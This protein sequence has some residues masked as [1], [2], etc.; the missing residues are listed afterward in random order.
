LQLIALATAN[1]PFF[2]ERPTGISIGKRTVSYLSGDFCPS[3][4]GTRRT[5][6]RYRPVSQFQIWIA[7]DELRNCLGAVQVLQ[8]QSDNRLRQAL[9]NRP[10]Q[11]TGT[12]RV[13]GP[14]PSWLEFQR[15]QLHKNSE[16]PVSPAPE[17]SM[18]ESSRG[19]I[20]FSLP[21][22][23][24]AACRHRKG[25]G[26]FRRNRHALLEAD[27]AVVSRFTRCAL[28]GFFVHRRSFALGRFGRFVPKGVTSYGRR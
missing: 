3:S 5:V 20:N 14:R 21:S 4:I 7:D 18:K 28:Y 17:C 13:I 9:G 16:I 24:W 15:N 27:V 8:I 23:F 12:A 19:S 6:A 10:D 25:L 26:M 1:P 11:I 22:I 2:A